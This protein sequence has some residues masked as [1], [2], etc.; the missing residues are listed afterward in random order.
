MAYHA[1]LATRSRNKEGMIVDPPHQKDLAFDCDELK[2]EVQKLKFVGLDRGPASHP[3]QELKKA[4]RLSLALL[5]AAT[6]FA[7]LLGRYLL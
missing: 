5:L 1:D 4:D 6:L 3:R 2:R 7:F